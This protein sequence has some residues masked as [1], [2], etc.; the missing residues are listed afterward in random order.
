MRQVGCLFFAL[1][2]LA[3]IT[4]GTVETALINVVVFLVL[5]LGVARF[6]GPRFGS[7]G[8]VYGMAG[9][10]FASFLWPVAVIIAQY[11]GCEGED[12]PRPAALPEQP[13]QEAP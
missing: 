6:L 2:F 1:T 7:Q 10:F 4:I 12:C 9:A 3:G 8:V 13:P 5:A 11:E